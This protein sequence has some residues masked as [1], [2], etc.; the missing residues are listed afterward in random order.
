VRE[1][2]LALGALALGIAALLGWVLAPRRAAPLPHLVASLGAALLGAA[3]G[4]GLARTRPLVVQGA[5]LGRPLVLADPLADG[6]LLLTMG[7]ATLTLLAA[8]RW[9]ASARGEGGRMAPVAAPVLVLAIAGVVLAGNGFAFVLCWELV[10]VTI[11]LLA[12]SRRSEHAAGQTFAASLATRAS[13]IGVLIG[14]VALA[15]SAHSL[16]IASWAGVPHGALR[17][18]AWVMLAIGFGAKM[19]IPPF[20]A[21]A[22]AAYPEVPGPLRALVAGVAFTVGPYGFLRM[23]AVIGAPPIGLVVL[24]LLVGGTGAILGVAFAATENRM[25]ALLAWSSVENA[26]VILVAL[27]LAGAG[28]AAHSTIVAT[29]GTL[30]AMLATIAHAVAKTGAFSALGVLGRTRSGMLDEMAGAWHEAP[31]ATSTLLVASLSLAGLPPTAG[32]V[33]EWFVLE[34]LMQQFRFH[35]LVLEV[36]IV[37][38]A[39]ATALTVGLAA[40]VFVRVAAVGLRRRAPHQATQPA[41][42]RGGIVYGAS[43]W[44]VALGRIGNGGLAIAVLAIAVLA[45]LEVSLLAH[46]LAPVVPPAAVLAARS[47]P[48]VLEPAAPGFSVLSPS[49]LAIVGP[50]LVLLVGLFTWVLSRGTLLR[51]RRVPRWTSASTLAPLG[52]AASDWP[53]GVAS[54]GQLTGPSGYRAFAFANPLRHVLAVLLRAE[55]SLEPGL[56]EH[57]A[58]DTT[59]PSGTSMTPAPYH[60][61]HEVR[62]PIVTL[63][64]VPAAHGLQAIARMTKRLQSGRLGAYLA[65]MLIALV[66]LL[67]MVRALH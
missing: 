27:G 45:P 18:F 26:G 15:A 14:V 10:S 40:L 11:L 12:A 3:G 53:P 9:A 31:V 1:L 49:W 59:E 47:G 2:L 7:L 42:E 52:E 37:L 57:A 5:W 39:A 34:A 4:L 41:G 54:K 35:G 22:P 24:M 21:W 58:H 23:M 8:A 62:E 61:T 55:P 32:F 30:A 65:Y 33:A 46:V 25:S 43:T 13:G 38:A 17:D 63:G 28:L 36:P 20:E 6:F 44:L 56:A 64:L 50:V 19:G 51:P 29:A 16:V 66:A 60:Y 48:W 67:A